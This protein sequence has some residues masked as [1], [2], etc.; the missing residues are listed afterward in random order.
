MNDYVFLQL[1]ALRQLSSSSL[2][3]DG[4]FVSNV[5]DFALNQVLMYVC[6]NTHYHMVLTIGLAMNGRT[7]IPLT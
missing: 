3:L 4:I 6:H 2:V 1:Y 5:W 7:F